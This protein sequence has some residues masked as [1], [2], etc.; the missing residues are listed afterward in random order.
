M[1]ALF[2]LLQILCIKPIDSNTLYHIDGRFI[3]SITNIAIDFLILYHLGF[4]LIRNI[5]LEPYLNREG[6]R[7][8]SEK[9]LS[10][11]EIISKIMHTFYI[12]RRLHCEQLPNPKKKKSF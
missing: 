6:G 10:R 2:K 8:K 12:C 7:K 5:T 4:I 9:L 3:L 1:G 11:L